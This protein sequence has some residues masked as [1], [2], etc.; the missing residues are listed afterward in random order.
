VKS[1][2][3]SRKAEIQ[4]S[5]FREIDLDL[6]RPNPEQ[7]RREFDGEALAS[8][9]QSLTNQGVL[10]PILVS[11]TEDGRYELVSGERRWRAAQLAG[12]L[13]IPA[14]VRPIDPKRRLEFALVE[15]LQRE[16]LNPV[17]VAES[18][19]RLLDETGLTQQ[20]VAERIGKPRTTVTNSLR[21]LSLPKAVRSKLIDGTVSTGHAKALLGLDRPG[22]QAELADQVVRQRLSVRQL[23]ALVLKE[24]NRSD[25]KIVRKPAQDPNVAHA[26]QELQKAL[27][28]KVRIVPSKKGGR[29]ELH[30]FSSEEL[31]KMYELVMK[32]ARQ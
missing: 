16:N 11:E 2:S 22:R 30:C 5:P 7:P 6:I 9:A 1:R 8:L 27:G 21:L 15:N 19:Q 25:V 28:T 4:R 24:K 3:A 20:E 23:E 14:L 29:I 32:A 13:R 17:E 26:E 18:Y 10:Q 31:D 12:L